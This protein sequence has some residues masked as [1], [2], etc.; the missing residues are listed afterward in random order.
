MKKIHRERLT[1]VDLPKLRNDK[2]VYHLIMYYSHKAKADLLK[3]LIGE[4]DV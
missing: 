3:L 2:E 1:K 4:C